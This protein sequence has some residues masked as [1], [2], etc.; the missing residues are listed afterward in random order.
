MMGEPNTRAPCEGALKY[1][2]PYF[3]KRQLI[4]M[5]GRLGLYRFQAGRVAL[6]WPFDKLLPW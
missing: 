4:L 5:L 1:D 3:I 6:K 2:R